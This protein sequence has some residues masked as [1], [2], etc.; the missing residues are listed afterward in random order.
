MK[1]YSTYVGLDAHKKEISVAV[2]FEDQEKPAEWKIAND[3]R[4]IRR[5]VRRINREG[6]ESVLYCY[7]AGPLGY[8]LSRQISAAGF[9]CQ[10]VAPSLIPKKPGSRVKTDRRDARELGALLRANLLTEVAPPTEE[11]ESIRNLCRC[12]ESVKRDLKRSRNRLNHFLLRLGFVY[13]G[14]SKWTQKYYLWIRGLVFDHEAD[15]VAFSQYLFL[16][17][18]LEEQLRSLNR[19]LEEFALREPYRKE[20]GYLRCFRGIDTLT[21][22]TLVAELYQFGRFLK[23][24]ELMSFLGLTPSEYSSADI[25]R[26]GS[27]TKCGNAHARRVLIEA[28]WHYRYRPAVGFNLRKRREGQ[29]PHVISIADKAQKRLHDRYFRLLLKGKPKNKAVTAVA[30]ELVGFIWA[31]LYDPSLA[32]TS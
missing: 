26:P 12:R 15:R 10:V 27:I 1:Y 18:Q 5:M 8:T 7:E 16:V 22:I 2:F 28:A 31:A 25:R 32:E 14:T 23:P 4:S 30:R 21:A 24:R 11:E 17:D 9:D 19:H 13:G 29:P 20:V 3:A 6:D